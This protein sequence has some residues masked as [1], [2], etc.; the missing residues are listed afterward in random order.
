MYRT[1]AQNQPLGE[2]IM[3]T[4]LRRHTGFHI[5]PTEDNLTSHVVMTGPAATR[6]PNGK[7]YPMTASRWIVS[8]NGI[9][10][11]EQS[12][13]LACGGMKYDREKAM[14]VTHSTMPG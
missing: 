2:P 5:V 3:F 7:D 1:G 10:V 9:R 12:S 11:D 13:M 4:E 6:A 14:G 8:L